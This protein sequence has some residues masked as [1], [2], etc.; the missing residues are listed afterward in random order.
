M[1][2]SVGRYSRPRNQGKGLAV[3]YVFAIIEGRHLVVAVLHGKGWEGHQFKV[4]LEDAYFQSFATGRRWGDP[5]L[6]F[7]VCRS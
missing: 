7:E 1:Q 6:V 3:K 2:K 4:F 5:I